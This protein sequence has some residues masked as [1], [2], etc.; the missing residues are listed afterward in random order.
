[1]QLTDQKAVNSAQLIFA[2][3]S[4]IMNFAEFIFA[5][6]RF[7]RSQDKEEVTTSMSFMLTKRHLQGEW[8]KMGAVSKYFL[9]YYFV[10]KI[11][12]YFCSL[13]T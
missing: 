13:C 1:M 12:S 4:R 9:E 3:G 2:I 5:M 10:K 6:S 11:W 7:K 8:E